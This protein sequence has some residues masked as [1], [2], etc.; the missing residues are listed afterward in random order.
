[1]ESATEPKTRHQP[2]RRRFWESPEITRYRTTVIAIFALAGILLHL[3]LRFRF[4]T[5]TITAEAPLFAV[6]ALGGIP[7]VYE[8]LRK[9]LRREFGSDLLAGI[10]IVTSVLL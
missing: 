9:L 6:L 3:L 5:N 8:L 7:L 1:M 2:P 4:R 10:S